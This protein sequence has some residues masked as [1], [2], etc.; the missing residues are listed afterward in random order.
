M[1]YYITILALLLIVGISSAYDLTVTASFYAT[2]NTSYDWTLDKT[3]NVTDL[4]FNHAPDPVAQSVEFT[5]DITRSEPFSQVH[6][7][8]NNGPLGNNIQIHNNDL[9]NPAYITSVK[10]SIAYAVNGIGPWY[11]VYEIILS[12]PFT[13]GAN[14]TVNIPLDI[15]FSTPYPVGPN[16]YHYNYVKVQTDD[17]GLFWYNDAF[18]VDFPGVVNE[19]LHVWDEYTVPN[20]FT[21]TSAYSPAKIGN[22]DNGNYWTTVSANATLTL[23]LSLT[24]QSA[25]AGSYELT[26]VGSGINECGNWSSEVT[27]SLNVK[28]P[29]CDSEWRGHCFGPGY[30]KSHC[31]R[32]HRWLPVCHPGG[33]VHDDDHARTILGRCGRSHTPWNQYSCHFL[34]T[35]FNCYNDM[36]LLSA[37]YNDRSQTGEFMEGQ[38]VAYIISTADAFDSHT[39]RATLGDMKDVFEAINNNAA[40]HVLWQTYGGG[41]GTTVSLPSSASITL[42]PNPFSNWTAIRFSTNSNKPVTL[43]VYDISGTKV[44]NLVKNGNST[45]YWD[46]TDN[47]G[48]K[49]NAGVYMLRYE[50]ATQPTT[51]KVLISR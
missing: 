6:L 11:F 28:P 12:G 30:W 39:T 49:L 47:N 25:T 40:T 13:L 19:S 15:T 17:A 14:A 37:Y 5:I 23:S 16:A 21:A 18:H 41:N 9:V 10:D 46:G 50:D 44:R 26:N 7:I 33:C 43:K 1:K 42:N 4:E 36:D 32:F 31:G 24:N 2:A 29:A 3:A 48:R 34:A 45:L 27:M 8:G 51:L 22:W 35:K 20:G 38:Q